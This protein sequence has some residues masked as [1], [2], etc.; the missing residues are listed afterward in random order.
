MIRFLC[1]WKHKQLHSYYAYNPYSYTNHFFHPFHR[2]ISLFLSVC[3]W[4]E[5]HLIASNL[6]LCSTSQ[7]FELPYTSS[8]WPIL[9]GV[10]KTLEFPHPPF[11]IPHDPPFPNFSLPQNLGWHDNLFHP[12]G[13]LS[14]LYVQENKGA[15][16]LSSISCQSLSS[17]L[18]HP[19]TTE[20]YCFYVLM[21]M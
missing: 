2:F 11:L 19:S 9:I 15:Y 13:S 6:S 5:S 8:K 16:F 17:W 3:L 20:Y 14:S 10:F 18:D 1:L 7:I 21:I 4:N 12:Y